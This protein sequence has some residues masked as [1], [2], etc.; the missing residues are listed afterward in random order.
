MTTIASYDLVGV[1][2]DVSD[3]ITNIAPTKTP[4]QTMIGT[5]GIHQKLYE[6]QE[7]TLAAVTSAPTVEG[8]NA[9]AGTFNPTV[10]RTNTTQIFTAVASVSGTT[11]VTKTYGRDKE[12]SYQLSL[13]AAELKRNL[14]W[15]MVGTGQT[16]TVGNDSTARQFA[17]YQAMIDPTVTFTAGTGGGLNY[18]GGALTRVSITEA[19]ILTTSEA[20]YVAGAEPDTLMICPADAI[21]VATF[22]STGRTKFVDNMEKTLVNVVDV[23][24]GPHGKLKVVQNRFLRGTGASGSADSTKDALIFEAPMWKRTPLRNWF[25]QTL[26]KVGDS[27]QVQ[28]LGEFGL[29]HRNYKASGLITNLL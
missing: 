8:A 19:M 17:G 25:R 29:K 7:D 28:I 15:A 1:K 6:W 11:E 13:R 16:Y 12:L 23:Y 22:S 14:E 2:E 9:P 4:F 26:A 27:T 20:L 5:E 3:I 10:L 21:T 24:E 18:S